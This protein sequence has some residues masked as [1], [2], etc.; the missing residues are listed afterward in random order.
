MIN[1]LLCYRIALGIAGVLGVG[2]TVWT[3]RLA[4]GNLERFE[5]W[6]RAKA[7]GMII[8]WIVLALCVPHAAVVSPGFLIPLLWPLAIG[9]PILGYFFVDYPLS[10]ALGGAAILGAYYLVHKSF[11]L[12]T[13]MFG[14]IAL[15][16]WILGIAGIWIS[17]KPCALRDW[18]RL[19]SRS[20][21]WKFASAG[22]FAIMTLALWWGAALTRGE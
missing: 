16:S 11:E 2:L 1:E 18:I 4:P 19:C 8:G 9:V 5:S 22:F 7:P 14:V 12:H 10:R 15:L 17:G 6:P 13:P 3:V 20:R 21:F